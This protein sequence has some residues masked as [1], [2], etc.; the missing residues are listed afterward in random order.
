MINN[1][2][3]LSKQNLIILFSGLVLFTISFLF[4]YLVGEHPEGFMGFLAPLT[5]LVGIIIITI[6]FLYKKNDK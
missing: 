3:K 5:M 1:H 6:G 4:I 2:D